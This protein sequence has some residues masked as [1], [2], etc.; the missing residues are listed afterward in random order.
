MSVAL[1]KGLDDKCCV[2]GIALY[3]N[4]IAGELWGT[5]VD[6]L[7]HERG[8]MAVHFCSECWN[9]ILEITNKGQGEAIMKR[10]ELERER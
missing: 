8:S 7:K 5:Y 2:C 9:R 3:Q 4:E 10:K 6:Y 1:T